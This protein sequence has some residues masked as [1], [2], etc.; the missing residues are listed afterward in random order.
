MGCEEGFLLL[1]DPEDLSV[2]VLFSP[3]SKQTCSLVYG[4][5]L[6]LHKYF[7]SNLITFTFYFCLVAEANPKLKNNNFQ[8]LTLGNKGLLVVGKVLLC[9]LIN[10]CINISS[11][12][13]L[14]AL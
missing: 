11:R 7:F 1:V 12:L 14:H 6:M 10:V 9:A 5:Y 4:K 3:T 8:G 13:I 2:S